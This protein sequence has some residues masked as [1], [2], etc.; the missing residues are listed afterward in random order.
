MA[1]RGTMRFSEIRRAAGLSSQAMNDHLKR[2]LASHIVLQVGEAQYRVQEGISEFNLDFL[3]TQVSM[4]GRTLVDEIECPPGA[5][6]RQVVIA[7]LW[8]LFDI[9]ED[10]LREQRPDFARDS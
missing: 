8:A 6:R 9:V 7:T 4:L 10:E 1:G 3:A 5:D 2:L